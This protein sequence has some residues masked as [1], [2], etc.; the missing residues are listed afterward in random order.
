LAT[1]ADERKQHQYENALSSLR[2][3][4]I[5]KKKPGEYRNGE[6]G[7]FIEQNKMCFLRV[8]PSSQ[9]HNLEDYLFILSESA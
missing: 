1:F 4:L 5:K 2:N 6:Q 8:Q 3:K 9:N 7:G